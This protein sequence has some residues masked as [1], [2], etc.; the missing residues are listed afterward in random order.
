MI[1]SARITPLPRSFCDP[2]PEIIVTDSTGRETMIFSYY[3]DEISFTEV[4]F[5]G[6]TLDEARK[7]KFTKITEE[8]EEDSKTSK[9]EY[10]R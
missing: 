6:L 10:R 5:V 9:R 4:E 3:P 8:K 2:V 7:L 1:V